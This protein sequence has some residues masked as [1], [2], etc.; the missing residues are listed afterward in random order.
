MCIR[1]RGDRGH[2]GPRVQV[3]AGFGESAL[4]TAAVG[5]HDAQVVQQRAQQEG[6]AGGRRDACVRPGRVRVRPED[7]VD[8]RLGGRPAEGAAGVD[9]YEGGRQAVAETGRGRGDV[10]LDPLGHHHQH[11]QPGQSPR[12]VDEPAPGRVVGE[13]DV[14]DGQQ[15]RGAGRPRTQ[16][17]PEPVGLTAVVRIVLLPATGVRAQH[18][19][20]GREG[21]A[22]LLGG[23]GNGQHLHAVFRAVT[24]G[25]SHERAAARP[26]GPAQQQQPSG[27]RPGAPRL[28]GQQAECFRTFEKGRHHTLLAISWPVSWP[29][30]WSISWSISW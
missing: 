13:V 7:G 18:L 24:Y 1:D 30:L 21:F 29:V 2:E 8:H 4:R 19:A 28:R 15:E 17:P 22:G 26:R 16:Q 25:G 11:G 12:G 23:T 20:Y 14:V 5:G 9:A 6:V 3:R 10:V 27:A